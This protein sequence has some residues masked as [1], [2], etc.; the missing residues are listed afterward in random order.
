LSNVVGLGAGEYNSLALLA[1]SIPVP[2]LLSPA[3]QGSRFSVLVQTLNRKNYALEFNPSIAATNWS[4]LSTNT[5]HG[6]LQLLTDPAA[7]ASQR[8]YRM[9]QW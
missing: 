6:A 5:G 7:T 8:Y 2:Q 9:R 4:A 1:G 3:R